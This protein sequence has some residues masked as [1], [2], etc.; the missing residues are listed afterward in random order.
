MKKGSALRRGSERGFSLIELLITIAIVAILAGLLLP[1]LAR[2]KGAARAAAC[3]SNLR[4]VHLS[5]S[6]YVS[7]FGAYPPAM[8]V[9]GLVYERAGVE[10][11]PVVWW[12]ALA[13][14]NKV[15]DRIFECPQ[16]VT[17]NTPG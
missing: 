4:Q 13:A 1:S 6:M 3:R 17:I 7:E 14:Y 9:F 16:D 15:P 5:L 12:L 2:G 10:L 8:G 11:H